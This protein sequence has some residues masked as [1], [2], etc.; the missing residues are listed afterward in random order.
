[1]MKNESAPVHGQRGGLVC[2]VMGLGKTFQAISLITE[3]LYRIRARNRPDEKT[4]VVCSANVLFEWKKQIEKH[5]QP[6]ILRIYSYYG[7]EKKNFPSSDDY[8]VML[9]SYET[10]S[11]EF[12]KDGLTYVNGSPVQFVAKGHRPSPFSRLFDRIIV[13]EAHNIRN[14]ETLRHRSIC[15]IN[16][17]KKWALTGT[18]IWNGIHDL[19]ALLKFIDAFPYAEKKTF[20]RFITS[21]IVQNPHEVCNR[22]SQF[23]TPLEI[24]RTKEQLSLPPL[25]DHVLYV[26]LEESE[27]LFYDSLYDFSRDTVRRLLEMHKWLKRTGWAMVNTSLQRRMKQHI[28]IIILRLRQA[29]IHPQLAI[30]ACANWR[31]EPILDDQQDI[32]ADTRLL[33][34]AASRLQRL[35]ASRTGDGCSEDECAICL[36]NKPSHAVIP[37]G[38]TFCPDCLAILQARGGY[39]NRC[40]LCRGPMQEYKL[41]EEALEEMEEDTDEESADIVLDSQWN[42]RS[43]KVTR[44]LD[45]I[46]QRLAQDPT[47]KV[48]IFSQW[49]GVLNIIQEGLAQDNIKNLR[50]DGSVSKAERRSELQEQFNTDPAISVMVCSLT[51]SS[52]GINLQSANLV[53]IM[54]PW[55]TPAR[56]EQAG[57]RAHR[58]GQ[59]RPVEIIHYIVRDSIEERILELQLRKKAIADATNGQRGLD[60]GW[61]GDIRRLLDL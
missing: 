38:H 32:L 31:N 8:D 29:C 33:Q 56:A 11:Q 12:N 28:L 43:T 27:R 4:L 41:I 51:C 39:M 7:P 9:T 24:R 25:T 3:S 37:C 55:W 44:M 48:L 45:T 17:E 21:C 10:V 49:L 2:D 46:K 34:S 40:A 42:V 36:T 18:P 53:F 30:D 5:L 19:Y 47:T 6:G 22:L 60:D 13:D 14:I 58:V 52:E 16:A 54:D 61:E 57:N 26:S 23:L 50:V 15:A 35:V 59:Q 1:M 20:D